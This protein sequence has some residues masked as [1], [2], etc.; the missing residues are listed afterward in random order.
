MRNNILSIIQLITFYRKGHED[1]E[2]RRII[3]RVRF[4]HQA[5]LFCPAAIVRC[6]LPLHILPCSS[7]GM[8]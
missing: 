7:V 3:C 1:N 2:G 4:T 5:A 8:Q 6:N